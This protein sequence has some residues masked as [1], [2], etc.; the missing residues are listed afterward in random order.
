MKKKALA[1]CRL[2]CQPGSSNIQYTFLGQAR[3][4]WLA[5]WM[6]K[7]HLKR[8]LKNHFLPHNFLRI[9]RETWDS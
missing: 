5:R 9:T 4:R 6:A 8:Y 1:T 7:Q 3:F 2:H